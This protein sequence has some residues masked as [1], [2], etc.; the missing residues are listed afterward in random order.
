[1]RERLVPIHVNVTDPDETAAAGDAFAVL[2]TPFD[3]TI[4]AVGVSPLEDDAGATLDIQD[5]G[6]DVITGVDAS[7]H[8]APGEWLSTYAGGTNDPVYVAAGS[9]IDLDFNNAAAANR[10]DVTIWA[11]IGE[12]SG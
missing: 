5:D 7:D 1:M 9:E 2:V 12:S 11:L 4:V 6:T 10:F 8:D 3:L